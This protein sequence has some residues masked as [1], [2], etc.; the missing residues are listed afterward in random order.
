MLVLGLDFETTGLN[1]ETDR[2]V[3]IGAVLWDTDRHAPIFLLN[4][5]VKGDDWPKSSPEAAAAH[6]ITDD[7]LARWG[8]EPGPAFMNLK[9]LM[10][11]AEWIVAHNGILFDKP[12]LV[13]H[14]KRLDI[15]MPKTPWA[16][17]STDI[18]FPDYIKTRKLTHL[19]SEHKFLNPFAHRAVFDVLTMLKVTEHYDWAEI[20]RYAKSPTLTVQAGVSFH[21]KDEAKSRGY[22]Y[23]GEKKIWVKS[24]KEF[25]LEDEKKNCPFIVTVIQKGAT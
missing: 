17:T 22:R 24:L 15:E 10:Q 25:Q 4:T 6:G 23:D 12:M 1:L 18:Q 9:A 11:E 7:D 5:L 19:A 13:N 21:T 20:V 16:D 2:I 3:E 8:E 14:L